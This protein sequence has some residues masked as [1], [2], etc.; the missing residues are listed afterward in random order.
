[1]FGTKFKLMQQRG[2][3]QVLAD[4]TRAF[5]TVHPSWVLRQRDSAS[6]AQAYRNF[7]DDL[8]LLLDA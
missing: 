6:R 4:G 2:V 1:V 7:T 8:S 5:A 3:W